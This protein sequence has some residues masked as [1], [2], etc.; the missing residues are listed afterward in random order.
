MK[1]LYPKSLG[2]VLFTLAF[3]ALSFDIPT[4]LSGDSKPTKVKPRPTAA[5]LTALP[6]GPTGKL[7]IEADA[8]C[9]LRVNGEVKLTLKATEPKIV[10]LDAGEQLIECISMQNSEAK[11]RKVQRVDAGNQSVLALALASTVIDVKA[12]AEAQAKLKLYAAKFRDS[13]N[14]LV[15]PKTVLQWTQSDNGVD[16]SWA[17]SSALCKALGNGWDLPSVVQLQALVD[18]SLSQSCGTSTC[19][20]SPRF[21]LTEWRFW[22]NERDDSL[23]AW[24]VGLRD[25]VRYAQPIESSYD[26]RALCVRRP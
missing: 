5:A 9:Q 25:G 13:A 20:V 26:W 16:I 8:P 3:Q 14:T 19:R 10:V 21:R 7:V 15:E 24:G 12:K 18:P 1:I 4:V 22:S 11:V 2:V 23:Q 17:E 6:N